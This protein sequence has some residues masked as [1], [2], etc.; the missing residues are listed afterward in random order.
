MLKQIV[1]HYRLQ[2]NDE[3]SELKIERLSP[4]A[5]ELSYKL[6]ARKYL[7]RAIQNEY[8]DERE[9]NYI[10]EVLEGEINRH[11][12]AEMTKSY[13]EARKKIKKKNH[14]KSAFHY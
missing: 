12:L 4:R 3:L 1:T 13:K 9:I 11:R 10:K 7:N 6:R 8:L 14:K 2:L 5:L